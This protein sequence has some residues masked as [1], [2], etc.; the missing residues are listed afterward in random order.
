MLDQ[1]KD[2]FDFVVSRVNKLAQEDGIPTYHAFSKWFAEFYFQNID[3]IDVYDGTGDGKIDIVVQNKKG[4]IFV[5][6]SKYTEEYSRNTPVSHYDE[7]VSFWQAFK[8]EDQREDYL[9]NVVRKNLRDKYSK[10]FRSYNDGKVKLFFLTNQVRNEKQH[11]RVKNQKIEYIYLDD[12]NNY[13][14]EF[15]ENAMPKTDELVL[16]DIQNCL[17]AVGSESIVPTSIVFARL[18]DF[19]KY[20]DNDPLDLLFARNV[21]LWLDTTE[22]NKEIQRTFTN[23]PEEFVY[24][25]N[26]ITILC[27]SH[28]LDPG[29][30]ELKIINPRVVNGSQTLHSIRKTTSPSIKARVMVKII[31]LP[32]SGETST[33]ERK[34]RKQIVHNISIRTNMQNPIKKENLVAN[35]DFQLE[36]SRYM[37]SKKY[38]YERRKNEWKI[39]SKDLKELR[40]QKGTDIKHLMQILS[41]LYYDRKGLG[42]VVSLATSG[43]IYESSNYKIIRETSPEIAFFILSPEIRT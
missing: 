42:P 8:N 7:I 21:R 5:I 35:D 9:Q 30:H 28:N 41:C 3:K 16:S 37:W 23:Y 31:S 40:I 6:N 26:G 13:L 10:L 17:T 27:D 19:I 33:A 14:L 1:R 22:T 25:N 43:D 4:N 34:K 39:K 29:L 12:L 24:S 11:S 15:L 2:L 36:L 32:F 38:Y 20:M 18:V